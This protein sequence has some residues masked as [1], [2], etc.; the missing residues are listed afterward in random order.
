MAGSRIKR[1][2]DTPTRYGPVSRSF[3]WITAYLLLWQSLM[4]IGWRVLGDGEFMRMT[5]RL[6]PTH[7]STGILVLILVIPRFLWALSNRHR[8]PPAEASAAGWLARK[9]S[10]LFYILMFVV[11]AL[12]V[13]RAYG[14]GKGCAL[15][16]LQ[17]IP[18]TGQEIHWLMAPA[19]LLHA[20]LAWL[21]ALLISGHILM[22]LF[23]ACI[24]RDRIMSRMV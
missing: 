8:R 17:L 12:A 11:P 24:G 9:V 14:S 13:I 4:A 15:W 2:G 16:G 21:L 7:V 23:H 6:G 18:G 1:L 5:S 19:N 22:A 20:P 3:H 10:A